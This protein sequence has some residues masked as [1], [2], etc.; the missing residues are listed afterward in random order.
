MKSVL[1][2]E[3]MRAPAIA[4]T[5]EGEP[6]PP[7]D[8]GPAQD[9]LA[10]EIVRGSGMVREGDIAPVAQQMDETPPGKESGEDGQREGR[11]AKLPAPPPPRLPVEAGEMP[12]EGGEH[13]V[14]QHRIL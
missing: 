9:D 10:P 7:P 14:L 1:G 3:Q 5:V 11:L 12:G 8:I 6:A 4:R 13:H 2:I